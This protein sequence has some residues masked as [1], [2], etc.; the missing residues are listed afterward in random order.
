MHQVTIQSAEALL[1]AKTFNMGNTRVSVREMDGV[2]YSELRL[3]GKRI[4]RYFPADH[5][6][7]LYDVGWQ[8]VTTKD[9]L[10]GILQIAGLNARIYQQGL[11]FDGIVPLEV[12]TPVPSRE[13]EPGP[14]AGTGGVNC[15]LTLTGS[16]YESL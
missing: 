7:I 12:L 8:T 4:A 10:N 9:R 13:P 5:K 14:G 2:L 6:L 1:A 15:G 11:I 3:H 16:N